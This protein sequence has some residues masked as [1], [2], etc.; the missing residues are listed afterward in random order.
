MPH[1]PVDIPTVSAPLSSAQPRCARARRGRAT[2]GPTRRVSA[3]AFPSSPCLVCGRQSF[4]RRCSP[5]VGFA[6]PSACPAGPQRW[7]TTAMAAPLSTRASFRAHVPVPPCQPAVRALCRVAPCSTSGSPSPQHPPRATLCRW[8]DFGTAASVPAL[9]C[10]LRFASGFWKE[11]HVLP[12]PSCLIAIATTVSRWASPGIPRPALVHLSASVPFFFFTAKHLP[13]ASPASALGCLAQATAR[14]SSPSLSASPSHSS[15]E[16][17]AEPARYLASVP[18]RRL[19]ARAGLPPWVLR[20]KLGRSL[21]SLPRLLPV[22]GAASPVLAMP[23]SAAEATLCTPV[24]AALPARQPTPPQSPLL[25][26]SVLVRLPLGKTVLDC[27]EAPPW[28]ASIAERRRLGPRLSPWARASMPHHPVDI[29]TV[30]APLSSAQPRCARARRGRA[31]AGPT[32]RVSAPAFPSSPCLV[33]GRQSFQRRCSPSVGFAKPSAC[34]AG[35]QRW[36]T[37]AM[38]APLSTRASFRAHV[39]VPPCQPAVRALCR[40]APCSTSG[41][42]S[43][44]HPPRATLCRWSDFGTAASVPALLCSLRF[45]SGFWKEGE[46]GV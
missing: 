19:R 42:P 9:L 27:T 43:P 30:S 45:A 1:H 20:A 5:S 31:T 8:S 25:L 13:A 39:P 33:C 35:P 24:H 41:S 10:S 7:T 23:P 2:A 3:P 12:R 46:E 32:R 17:R 34:P 26:P 44:Q 15:A 14:P 28:P 6:K 11:V 29:P 37:A 22:A 36:T 38:A 18:H 16:P 21:C 40:A 4:Q